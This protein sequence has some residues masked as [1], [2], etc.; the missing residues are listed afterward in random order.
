MSLINII[1]PGR[2]KMTPETVLSISKNKSLQLYGQ[3]ERMHTDLFKFIWENQ[4]VTPEQIIEQYGV[5]AVTLFIVSAKIQEVL[6]LV[7]PNYVSLQPTKIPTFNDDG[8]VT[9]A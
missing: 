7:N 8:T 4:D 1:V 5:D 9:L 6:A 2:P 3:L